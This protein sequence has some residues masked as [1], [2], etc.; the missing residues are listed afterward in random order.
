MVQHG[1]KYRK[2]AED[3][4][5]VLFIRR[6]NFFPITVIALESDHRPVQL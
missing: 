1:A 6:S 3:L 4:R 5:W 2:T